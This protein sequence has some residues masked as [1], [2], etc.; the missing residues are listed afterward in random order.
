MWLLALACTPVTPANY[1]AVIETSPP[2]GATN[3]PLDAQV[4]AVFS[5]RL[6]EGSLGVDNLGVEDS[7]GDEITAGVFYDDSTQSIRMS[8]AANLD[9]GADYTLVLG[10]AITGLSGGTLGS[11]I[12]S[13]F[14]TGGSISEGGDDTAT[15]T[16]L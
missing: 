9:E 4:V 16:G 2:H 14:R 11:E 8:P 6:S 7:N 13:D 10:S 12:R 15:D 1:L 5:E 3:V